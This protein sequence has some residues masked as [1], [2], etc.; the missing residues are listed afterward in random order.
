MQTEIENKLVFRRRKQLNSLYSQGELALLASTV[1]GAILIAIMH[2]TADQSRLLEWSCF[3][4]FVAIGRYWLIKTYVRASVADTAMDRWRIAFV[5]TLFASGAAWGSASYFVAPSA[6]VI[7]QAVVLIFIC[8]FVAAGVAAFSVDRFAFVGF[9]A[10][11]LGIPTAHIWLFSGAEGRLLAA[12]LLLF[13]CFLLANALR[14][15]RA[16]KKDFD[17]QFENQQLALK[18]QIEKN[19][20]AELA[21]ELEVRV[22]LR[23]EELSVINRQL[24]LQIG[25]KNKAEHATRIQESRFLEV[26]DHAPI[27]ML[28][29]E[30][31]SGKVVRA[32]SAMCEFLGYEAAELSGICAEKLFCPSERLAATGGSIFACETVVEKRYLHRRGFVLWG[33][34]SIGNLAND[35]LG[36]QHYV[37]QV[38][39]LSELKLA[40]D[41]LSERNI[42]LETAFQAAPVGMAV[43]DR[44]GRIMSGN[45]CLQSI[46]GLDGNIEGRSLTSILNA[47]SVGRNSEVLASLFGGELDSVEFEHQFFG[48]AESSRHVIIRITTVKAHASEKQFA[49]VHMRDKLVPQNLSGSNEERL[50]SQPVALRAL[51]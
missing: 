49:V 1:C 47:T 51:A 22:K 12:V 27:G 30:A 45:R 31:R 24:S 18:L 43:I 16:H 6:Q 38:E 44:S 4:M 50:E 37:I 21:E 48:V 25:E 46:L 2:T 35:K 40:R 32:N 9:S 41:D 11:A 39:D 15:N 8:G 23:T 34:T 33:R 14:S 19:K 13:G 42:A 5:V 3:M 7:D 17:T 20:I 29:V 36:T 28:V 26:F 10:P